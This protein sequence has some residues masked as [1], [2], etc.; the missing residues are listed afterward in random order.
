MILA[1]SRYSFTAQFLISAA[2]FARDCTAI[3]KANSTSPS[4]DDRSRHRGLV[5]AAI[6]H[7]V[8]AV[9]CEST[10]LAVHGPGSHLGSDGIDLAARE[11]LSGMSLEIDEQPVLDRFK[12]MLRVLG[13]A[14]LN[15]GTAPWQDMST[16]IKIRNEIVHYKS[17]WGDD[18]ERQVFFRDTLPR[19]K[20]QKP[21]FIHDS[22]NLFPHRL[23]GA[24]CAVW[25][26]KTAKAVINKVYDQHLGIKSPLSSHNER[27]AVCESSANENRGEA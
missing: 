20:L 19:L 2:I 7:S 27:L 14:P 12:T 11:I 22:Q 24:A 18:M 26:V 6:M 8:A 15:L 1:D 3:E 16:L 4:E 13:K 5:T 17:Q 9:E 10:E 25:A 21:P 23:L